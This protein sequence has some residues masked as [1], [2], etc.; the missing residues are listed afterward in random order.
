MCVGV[1]V[2]VF[3]CLCQCEKLQA[4]SHSM[5]EFV[6]SHT[7]ALISPAVNECSPS[8]IGMFAHMSLFATHIHLCL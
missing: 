6:S 3:E 2:R 4:W 8:L 5:F 1:L 7:H